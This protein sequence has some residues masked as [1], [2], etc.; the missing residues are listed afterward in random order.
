MSDTVLY[1]KINTKI[2]R[3]VK[4]CLSVCNFL[5]RRSQNAQESKYEKVKK[6][7]FS[8]LICIFC[9]KFCNSFDKYM[10]LCYNDFQHKP[11][12]KYC[13]GAV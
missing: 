12:K 11:L 9:R 2:Y 13:C 5:F 6:T 4:K 7:Q 8:M 3:K 10:H 1:S